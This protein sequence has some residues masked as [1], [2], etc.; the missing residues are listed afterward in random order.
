MVRKPQPTN[1][2][3]RAAIGAIT[4]F[5][6]E[7]NSLSKLEGAPPEIWTRWKECIAL[8][9]DNPKRTRKIFLD[10]QLECP[11]DA[12]CMIWALLTQADEFVQEEQLALFGTKGPLKFS[13]LAEIV[14]E[15]AE[16]RGWSAE[17]TKILAEDVAEVLSDEP[18]LIAAYSK[19]RQS[20]PVTHAS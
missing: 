5:C 8:L 20:Q 17:L 13:G 1:E 11:D 18:G 9:R 3:L 14:C 12:A 19:L 16:S 7:F 10:S 15:Y 2:Q 4:T 6:N